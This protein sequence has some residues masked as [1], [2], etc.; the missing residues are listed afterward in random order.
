MQSAHV[1]FWGSMMKV[2]V[3][4]CHPGSSSYT[5]DVCDSFINGLKE[6]GHEIVLH[7]YARNLLFGVLDSNI[8]SIKTALNS[9]GESS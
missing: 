3:V 2:F 6:A 8:D 1:V 5:H 4:Y 9:N 7:E